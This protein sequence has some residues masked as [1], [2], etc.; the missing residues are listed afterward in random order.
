M[1][2]LLPHVQPNLPCLQV[3]DLQRLL[4]MYSRW[5]QRI[6]PHCPFDDFIARLEKLSSSHIL[7]V[8]EV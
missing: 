2:A 4:E 3:A 8:Q 1:Y 6:F 7:K 5:Q